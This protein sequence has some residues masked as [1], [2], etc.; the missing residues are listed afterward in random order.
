MFSGK[1]E[2]LIE[3]LHAAV[4]SGQIVAA[5]KPELD[6]RYS[7]NDIVS[8]SRRAFPAT[9]I[10]VNQRIWLGHVCATHDLVGIDEVQFFGPW[11]VDE[12]SNLLVRGIDVVVSG[13]DLTFK[14]E[15]FGSVPQLLC[16][17]DEIH[18]LGA[19]CAKCGKPANRS[20]RTVESS[21]AVLVGGEEAYEPRCLGCFQR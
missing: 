11:I 8:H 18:K 20:Q 17:A 14:G 3:R 10:D 6:S 7:S 9:S 2:K 1:T 5:F 16:L 4:S 19:T 15:P 21:D 13:L 12:V